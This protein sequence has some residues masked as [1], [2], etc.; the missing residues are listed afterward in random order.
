LRIDVLGVGVD[1]LTGGEAVARAAELAAG[2]KFSYAVTP[3]PE[4]ILLAK[5]NAAFRAALNAADL[6]VADGIGVVKAAKILGRPLKAKVPG[7]DLAGGLCGA[8]AKSGGRLFL[9]GAKPGVAQAAG[10]KL[11]EKYPGLTICGVHDGYFKE[12]G[13]VIEEI[14]ASAADV[15][16]VCLGAPKQELW[17]AQ[18]GPKT[19]AKLMLGLGGSLDVFAGTVERAP[20]GWQRLGLEWLHRLLREPK[21]IGRMAKLPLVLVD[22][23]ACRLRGK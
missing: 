22:A 1:S 17:M 20:Q 3:N 18:Y 12:D 9:L 15:V 5:K 19:G 2:D 11:I 14:R 16:F 8:L 13:P 7:I 21:R 4:F 23:A 6:V 10:E